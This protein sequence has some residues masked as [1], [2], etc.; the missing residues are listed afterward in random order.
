MFAVKTMSVFYSPRTD[1]EVQWG[2][3]PSHEVL[4]TSTYLNVTYSNKGIPNA[5]PVFQGKV[6]VPTKVKIE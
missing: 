2:V 6:N 1:N 4:R 5:Y 3:F